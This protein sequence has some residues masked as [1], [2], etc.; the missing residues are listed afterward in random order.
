MKMEDEASLHFKYFSLEF[1]LKKIGVGF[2]D[3]MKT[4]QMAVLAFQPKGVV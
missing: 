4:M 3:E 2:L 1:Q